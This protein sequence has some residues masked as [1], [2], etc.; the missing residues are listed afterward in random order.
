V[1]VTFHV[2]IGLAMEYGAVAVVEVLLPDEIGEADFEDTLLLVLLL[3]LVADDFAELLLLATAPTPTQYEEP[4]QKL[5][6][7]S[8]ETS[9]FHLMKLTCEMPY[10]VSTE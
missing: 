5:V 2:E 7:Q 4:P 1:L 8:S 6:R 9:G 3:L 10:L